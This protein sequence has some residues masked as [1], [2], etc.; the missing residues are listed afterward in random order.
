MK[1]VLIVDD[2]PEVRSLLAVTLDMGEFELFE[3]SNGT[4]ALEVARAKMPDLML[5]DVMMPGGLD[6]YQVCEQLKAD[7]KTKGIIVI[8]LT[9]RGQDA[10]KKRGATVGADDYFIKPFSPRELL[11]KVYAALKI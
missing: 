10:D 4:Q 8:L 3:A 11:D 6:G 5:L 1:K 2:R 9:A 7:E